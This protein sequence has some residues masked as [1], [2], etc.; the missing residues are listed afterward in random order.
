M[1][2]ACLAELRIKV[3]NPIVKGGDVVV[4]CSQRRGRRDCGLCSALNHVGHAAVPGWCR[5][6]RV[7]R[8][9][10]SACTIDFEGH[11]EGVGI[12]SLCLSSQLK[13]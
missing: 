5:H 13:F 8:V 7:Y 2:S 9:S 11:D 1:A 6:D 12:E 3:T 10:G 4:Q